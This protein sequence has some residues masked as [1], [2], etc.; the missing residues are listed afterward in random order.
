MRRFRVFQSDSYISM[1]YGNHAG[2]VL[3]RNKLGLAR[4]DVELDEKNALAEEL[5]DFIAAVR[6]TGETGK[7]HD[8]RVSG[9]QGLKALELAIA[10]EAEARR[11]NQEYGFEFPAWSPDEMA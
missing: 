7:L 1:D 5:E 9:R 8:C 11:Y 4:K 10:I 2:M 6:K 3:K